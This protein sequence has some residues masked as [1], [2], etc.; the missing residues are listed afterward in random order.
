MAAVTS[1]SLFSVSQS[2]FSPDIL[3]K[4]SSE[5]NQPIEKTKTSLKSVIPTLLMG[6]VNKGST[7]EGAESLVNMASKQT[8]P[9]DVSADTATMKEGN[10]FLNDI[11]GNNLSYT[12]SSLGA[13]TGMNISC[14][15]KMLGMLAPMVMGVIGSKIK[16]E[17]LSASSLMSFLRKQKSSLI[18]LIPSGIPGLSGV[19]ADTSEKVG[20]PKI[21]LAILL[22]AGAVFWLNSTK[23]AFR[24]P[25][26]VVTTSIPSL[27]T[28]VIIATVPKIEALQTFMDSNV[29]AGTI[30]RFRF[31]NLNFKTGTATL[32][33]GSELEINQIA[34]A[35]KAHPASTARI[36]GFT[37][38]VG[39][40]AMNQALS[41]ERA[42]AVKDQLVANGIE[43]ERITAMGMGAS[44]PIASNN[45]AEGRAQNRRIELVIQR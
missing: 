12:V 17:K 22:I 18:G 39:S 33:S 37:D 11:F 9:V 24:Q 27:P 34:S 36:E 32:M 43:A 5:I 19:Q 4:I 16:N 28:A 41:T 6:I 2:F 26:P 20:W 13:T 38:N 25:A 29:P 30:K 14:V 42:M 7:K 10:E 40:P 15:S 1:D 35:M 8:A 31:E 3:Q 45:S 23:L 21:V 44:N